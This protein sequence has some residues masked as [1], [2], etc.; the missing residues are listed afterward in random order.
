MNKMMR[1]A[2]AAVPAV[3]L[4]VVAMAEP[5]KFTISGQ[6]QGADNDS[7]RVFVS[8]LTGKDVHRADTLVA[9]AKN[10]AFSITGTAP[11]PANAY[12]YAGSLRARKSFTFFIE[13]GTIIVRGHTDSLET[14][15][16]TGTRSN[17]DYTQHKK[18]EHG[19]YNQVRQLQNQYKAGSGNSEVQDSLERRM[20]ALRGEI[21]KARIAFIKSH[22]AS[23]ASGIYLY[24]LQDKI[25]VNLL[26]QLYQSLDAT[27]QQTGFMPPIPD[28]IAARK[29]V[30]PG[31][32]APQ[33][34]MVDTAGKPVQLASY[35][36]KYVLLDF[37]ASWCVPCRAE[38]PHLVK[39]YTKYRHKGFEIVSISVDTNGDKWKQAIVKDGLNWTHLS[40]L[41]APNPVAKLYS[42]QPIPDNFLIDPN[43][44]IL[45]RG[46]RG[47]EVEEKLAALLGAGN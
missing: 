29:R 43:G 13:P 2:V 37:W 30:T 10:G 32:K 47:N 28:K 9:I 5:F 21:D 15:D 35:K 12:G 16:I 14:I 39:A 4:A 45:A 26:E 1:L 19:F 23:M 27:V 41:A 8:Y 7:I 46:L 3:M 40:D 38:N 42:V 20:E 24:V 33:F 6:I 11:Q 18:V 17:E 34:T 25:E 44:K 31:N 36:G 22:P